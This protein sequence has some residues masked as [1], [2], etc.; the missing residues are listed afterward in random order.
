MRALRH[1]GFALSAA[2]ALVGFFALFALDACTTRPFEPQAQLETLRI[3]ALRMDHPTPAPGTDVHLEMLA[4]DGSP[5]AKDKGGKARPVELA[6]I[7]GCFD[8]SGDIYY[9]C[10][11]GL[12]STLDAFDTGASSPYVGHGNTYTLHMADDVISRRASKSGSPPYGIAFVFYA[13][14]AGKVV[15]VR[16]GDQTTPPLSCVDASGEAV[17]SDGFVYGYLPIY[18]YPG[19]DNK[20]PIVDGSTFGG[21]TQT[22]TP[23]TTDAECLPSQ[24][25]GT[26]KTCL[27]V[28]SPCTARRR[29]DCE[30]HV[31]SPNVELASAEP[32][33]LATLRAKAPRTE[34]VYVQYYV[35]L[36]TL[37]EDS[38]LI[39]DAVYGPKESWETNW[40]APGT[41]GESR[42]WAVVRDN[43]EGLTWVWQDVV[44]R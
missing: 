25:C 41:P 14:C 39:V 6:W 17:G 33:A 2:P 31:F 22:S 21:V 28:V 42:I 10:Y 4:F 32:D 20:N 23:C 7:G 38:R 15:T 40:T 27:P 44:V 12:G 36:G 34:V 30:T 24:A 3:I 11:P 13:A 1:P 19:I 9:K 35:S 18:S 43:R 26:G 16:G 5:N 8:P 37:G 29:S